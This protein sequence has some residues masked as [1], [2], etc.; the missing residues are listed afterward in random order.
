MLLF[1]NTSV[2]GAERRYA[3]VYHAL[4]RRNVPIVLAINESL[5]MRLRRL[6]IFSEQEMP[7]LL[8]KERVGRIA[9]V[10][11]KLDYVLGLLPVTV[12]IWR[13][14]P[15][16]LHLVLGGAYLALP[17]QLIG[18]APRAVLSVVCP[19]LREMV[20]STTGLH[21]YRLALRLAER[22]DALTESVR[23]MVRE[24]G[25]AAERI[26][27]PSGSCVDEQRFR[28]TVKQPWVVF[29]GRLIPEKDPM[30]FVQACA[31]ARERMKDRTTELRMFLLGDGPLRADV[32]A[33]IEKQGLGPWMTV[34]WN[35][36]VESVLS[37]AA[38]FV[39]VQRTDNYPSQSLLEAMA[40][41]TAIVATDVGLTRKLVD[42]Q[43]GRLVS[44]TPNAVAEAIVEL[45]A[46]PGQTAAMGLRARERVVQ[47]HSLER[48][49]DYIQSVYA[50]AGCP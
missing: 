11:R 33:L 31:L 21:F 15:Q 18:T 5:F 48:Y 12:W 43:V 14:R 7:D 37:R 40:S 42:D 6:G 8:L 41:G 2:G 13:R 19:S 17:S 45:L 50:M 28:P 35:D 16:V 30:M 9:F 38:V 34:G 22:V 20:G 4:R 3:W 24:E 25:V 36:Q 26:S 23:Q 1:N 29:S 47:Q 10:L 27:M 39:S 44:A 32:E 46:N 49:L